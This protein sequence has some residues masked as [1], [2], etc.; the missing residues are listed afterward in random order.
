MFISFVYSKIQE[1]RLH[2]LCS[3]NCKQETSVVCYPYTIA[4]FSYW[5]S[6][7]NYKS[8]LGVDFNWLL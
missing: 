8:K 3:L 6:Y 5:C 4:K 1:E 2:L 7:I